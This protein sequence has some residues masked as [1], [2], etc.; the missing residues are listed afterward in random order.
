MSSSLAMF[1]SS[2]QIFGDLRLTA[3]ERRHED[4]RVVDACS[5]HG[6][7]R[8]VG[9]AAPVAQIRQVAGKAGVNGQASAVQSLS[10]VPCPTLFAY[11]PPA[12]RL[13]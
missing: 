10:I 3:G 12:A 9:F 6:A 4:L 13:A 7:L 5:T 11:Q 2:I 8:A 1:I